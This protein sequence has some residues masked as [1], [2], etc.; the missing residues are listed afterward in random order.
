M[1]AIE[2]KR[3]FTFFDLVALIVLLACSRF[4]TI[5]ILRRISMDPDRAFLTG[6][7]IFLGVLCV[8][9]L[10]LKAG[11][12]QVLRLREKNIVPKK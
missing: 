6:I 11:S 5:F 7:P 1:N 8:L 2:R 10:L 4:I 12:Q 9:I 3:Y